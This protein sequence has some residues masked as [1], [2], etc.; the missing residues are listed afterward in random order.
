MRSLL[1]MLCAWA[2]EGACL[3][4]EGDAIRAR[5]L[6]AAV[7]AFG[8]L[9]PDAILGH[10]PAPGARRVF[11]REELLR[12]ARLH[13]LQP[14]PFQEVCFEWPLS[15]LADEDL[16]AAMRGSLPADVS[17]VEIV[18]RSRFPVP[19]GELIFRPQGLTPAPGADRTLFYW[20]GQLRYAGTRT[21]AVWAKVRIA[22][23]V[24]RVKALVALE[25]GVPV[26]ESQLERYRAEGSPFGGTYASAIA[27][28]VGRVPRIAIPAGAPVR[29]SELST[30]PEI[31]A[32]ERVAVEVRNGAMRILAEGRAERPART[33]ELVSL[34]NPETGKRFQARAEARGRASINV[35]SR[36]ES[37]VK[38]P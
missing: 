27:Q 15:R 18:D 24:W 26:E 33:G 5:D 23:T 17:A 10:A 34:I 22:A 1:L 6:A 19:P 8:A 36:E 12:L 38:L 2:L 32:G 20:K 30:P 29:M 16:L 37:R 31:A 14:E 9:A 11:H 4:V 21:L 7:P 3:P 13:Q 25:R 28:A 35:R